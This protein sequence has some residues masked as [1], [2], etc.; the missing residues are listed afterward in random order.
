MTIRAGR[1]F[2]AGTQGQRFFKAETG[3]DAMVKRSY[4]DLFK[5][6]AEPDDSGGLGSPPTAEEGRGL[7][8]WDASPENQ[9]HRM[10]DL[11]PLGSIIQEASDRTGPPVGDIY[12][13]AGAVSHWVSDDRDAQRQQ[14]PTRRTGQPR[15]GGLPN[16]PKAVTPQEWSLR[17][18]TQNQLWRRS[19]VENWLDANTK[20]GP[21]TPEDGE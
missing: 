5:A 8:E 3:S 7:M 14:G 21:K 13:I 10:G 16:F 15:R 11:M 6:P 18:K 1:F 19:D 4:S 12:E 2:R 17:G 20:L 9:R